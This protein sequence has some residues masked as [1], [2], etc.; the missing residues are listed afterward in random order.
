MNSNWKIK[1]V[2]FSLALAQVLP[3]FA[4]V[5]I[6]STRIIYP[7]QGMEKTIEFTNNDETPSVM[8]VWVDSG[9]ETSSP[10]TSDAPF[11]LTPPMFRID[12]DG[13]QTIRIVYTG[14]ELPTDRESIFYFNSVQIPPSSKEQEDQNRMLI[15]LRNRIKLFYR[16]K[17]IVGTVEQS[18]K[19]LQF[20]L[21]Q[22][23]KDWHLNVKNPSGY[24]VTISQAV[25]TQQKS[26]SMTSDMVSPQ[27]E[28][29][30]VINDLEETPQFPLKLEFN[31]VD[32]FGG[33]RQENIEIVSTAQQ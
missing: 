33:I 32:D 14:E 7:S 4:S 26:H 3:A 10:A 27:S 2:V 18:I 6:G 22:V 15:L 19:Q 25:I 9:D 1:C 13:R 20:S 5:V 16:P 30:W 12:P 21:K 31:Y 23:G 8:Q 11:I 17:T 28:A 24:F 29:N